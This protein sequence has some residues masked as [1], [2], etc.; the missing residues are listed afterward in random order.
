MATSSI[1]VTARCHCR[2]VI[3]HVGPDDVWTPAFGDGAHDVDDEGHFTSRKAQARAEAM[4]HPDDPM[5]PK[6][7]ITPIPLGDA[8]HRLVGWCAN[9]GARDVSVDEL[10]RKARKARITGRATTALCI[11]AAEAPSRKGKPPPLRRS[12]RLPRTAAERAQSTARIVPIQSEV[13]PGVE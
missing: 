9:H 12:G 3:G 11:E 5:S 7:D 6:I 1:L 2:A 8:V 13:R 4:V 10:R